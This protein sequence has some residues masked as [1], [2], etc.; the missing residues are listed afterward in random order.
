[1]HTL[2]LSYEPALMHIHVHSKECMPWMSQIVSQGLT[3]D[4]ETVVVSLVCTHLNESHKASA[5]QFISVIS[6]FRERDMWVIG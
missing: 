4:G 2:K 3:I 5:S 6:H 1:M